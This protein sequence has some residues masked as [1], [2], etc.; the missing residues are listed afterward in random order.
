MPL[1][2]Q[3][4]GCLVFLVPP[5]VTIPLRLGAKALK[6]QIGDLSGATQL[7]IVLAISGLILFAVALVQDRKIGIEFN[8]REAWTS[9]LME[10]SHT[11]LDLPIR[12]IA[13]V[14]L[15]AS[16]VVPHL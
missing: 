1:K 14:Y 8:S 12:L 16:L 6:D 5:L 13:V 4:L 9:R 11:F 7:S 3:R 2:Y 15:V 10:S